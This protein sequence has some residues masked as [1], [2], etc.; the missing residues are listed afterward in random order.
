MNLVMAFVAEKVR[1]PTLT[2][3]GSHRRLSAYFNVLALGYKVRCNDW[4]LV[5][6][7][8]NLAMK[9][10]SELAL[11]RNAKAYRSS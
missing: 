1:T 3:S 4:L 10:K 5:H 8:V 6:N 11:S 7:N 2:T 9:Q